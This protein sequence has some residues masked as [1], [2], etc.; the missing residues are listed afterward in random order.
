VVTGRQH[1]QCFVPQA[2]N[3]G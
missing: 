1:R 3:T 2:V